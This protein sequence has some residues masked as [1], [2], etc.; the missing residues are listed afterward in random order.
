LSVV[1]LI[2]PGW[3]HSKQQQNTPRVAGDIKQTDVRFAR[4]RGMSALSRSLKRAGLIQSRRHALV[5]LDRAAWRAWS[6]RPETD[7]PCCRKVTG[8]DNRRTGS[9]RHNVAKEKNPKA[10]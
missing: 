6:R 7:L 8:A 1:L 3:G 2:C 5:L 10:G 9:N 4:F